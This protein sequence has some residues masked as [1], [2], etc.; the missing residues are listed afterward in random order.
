MV[1]KIKNAVQHHP[2]AAI[3]LVSVLFLLTLGAFAGYVLRGPL[4]SGAA[5][6]GYT[7]NFNATRAFHA[8]L[9]QWSNFKGAAPGLF[10][11]DVPDEAPLWRIR[12]AEH[13]ATTGKPYVR[14]AQGIG[15]CVSWGAADA[16]DVSLAV[17]C[18]QG[19]ASGWKTTATEWVYGLRGEMGESGGYYQDG[20]WGSSAGKGLNR[21]GVVHR[22]VISDG[23]HSE[24]LTKYDKNRAR[25]WGHYGPGGRGSDWM[26]PIGA[27]HKVQHVALIRTVEEATASLANG[28]A[29]FVCSGVGFEPCHRNA[30]GVVRRGGRWPHCMALVGY[31]TANGRKVYVIEQSWGPNAVTGPE[32]PAKLS[33][34][35]FG[36][37]GQDLQDILDQNDSYAVSGPNGFEP[38]ELDFSGWGTN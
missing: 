35:Q 18:S 3:S 10:R 15:D 17:A 31:Y 1:K 20:W 23:T 6:F 4:D 5:R 32:G 27:K 25:D 9:G 13:L 33:G 11:G 7:P 26:N 24:D 37:I 19:K 16:V 29:I 21:F 28:Y 12:D 8:T 34:A 22:E 30:D 36:I 2:K 14:G 38:Q